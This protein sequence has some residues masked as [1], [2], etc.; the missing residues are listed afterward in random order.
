MVQRIGILGGGQLAQMLC[1]SSI[2]LGIPTNVYCESIDSPASKVCSSIT[3]G[4]FSETS[5]R[6]FFSKIDIALFESEFVDIP[7]IRLA[8]KNL[9]IK[10]IS[11]LDV[12]QKLQDKLE[13]KILCKKFNLPTAKW[14][15]IDPLDIENSVQNVLKEFGASAVFKWSRMGYDGKG[16]FFLK[17]INSQKQLLIDFIENGVQKGAT[18]YAEEAIAFER[19][20]AIVATQSINKEYVSYPVVVSEQTEGVCLNVFGAAEYFGVSPAVIT[21]VENIARTIAEK[22]DIHGTFAVELFQTST[23][24]FVN[25]IAPRVH[26]TG[27]YSQD[28]GIISQ[29]EN[30]I[31]AALEY[32]L[33][34]TKPSVL[35]GMRNILGP[36]NISLDEVA[37]PVPNSNNHS[38]HW[39][40]KNGTRPGRKL[41]HINFQVNS[42]DSNDLL[43]ELKSAIQTEELWR[44]L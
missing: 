42:K 39:Y 10:F 26:N 2:Q 31:R 33:G 25:E 34:Y 37:P 4:D 6:E 38:L 3:I 29:F 41:G 43:D 28:A 8:S 13:Q 16:N 11:N 5:L 35:F 19:E 30:H 7:T 21:E 9:P 15:E 36:K 18:I 44:K 27:H 14:I 20:L 22:S 17:D 12:M 32:P 40:G 24:V 1:Q 23:G